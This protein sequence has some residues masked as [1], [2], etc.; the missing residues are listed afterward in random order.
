MLELEVYPLTLIT[1][2][3]EDGYRFEPHQPKVKG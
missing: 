3:F 2:T 1:K